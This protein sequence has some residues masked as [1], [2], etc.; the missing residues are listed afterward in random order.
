MD[1]ENIPIGT[2]L[3]FQNGT[4]KELCLRWRVHEKYNTGYVLIF[5]SYSKQEHPH[6]IDFVAGYRYNTSFTDLRRYARE[7]SLKPLRE[8]NV[9]KLLKAIDND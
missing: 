9:L 3:E 1:F 6:K 5:E 4:D 7:G 2:V 8:S